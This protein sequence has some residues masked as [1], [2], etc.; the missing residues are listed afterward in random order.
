MNSGISS[1]MSNADASSAKDMRRNQGWIRGSVYLE[2]QSQMAL[3]I[4]VNLQ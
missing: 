3:E 1:A 2:E 4:Q